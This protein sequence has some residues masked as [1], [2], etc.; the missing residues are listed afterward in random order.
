MPMKPTTTKVSRTI[1][2]WGRV[3]IIGFAFALTM[4]IGSWL[5]DCNR[6]QP[7]DVYQ[8]VDERHNQLEKRLEKMAD[9]LKAVAD[10][11]DRRTER[12]YSIPATGD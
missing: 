12:V 2:D 4:L 5:K 9:L 7:A 10:E 3:A 6:T 1:I 8:R 11:Q